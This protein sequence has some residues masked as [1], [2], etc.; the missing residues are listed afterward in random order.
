MLSGHALLPSPLGSSPDPVA[1]IRARPLPRSISWSPPS[2]RTRGR[3][4]WP[5]SFLLIALSLAGCFA[6]HDDDAPPDLVVAP[7]EQVEPR[8]T[9][10]RGRICLPFAPMPEHARPLEPGIIDGACLLGSVHRTGRSGSGWGNLDLEYRRRGNTVERWES[11][12]SHEAQLREALETDAL[13]RLVRERDA[14]TGAESS[15]EHFFDGDRYAGFHTTAADSER[16]VEHVYELGRL[17]RT[18]S[19]YDGALANELRYRYDGEGRL[20]HGEIQEG[21][22]LVT[23]SVEWTYDEAGNPIAVH[24]DSG[25]VIT[26]IAFEYDLAGNLAR[27]HYSS[28]LPADREPGFFSPY[29]EIVGPLDSYESELLTPNDVYRPWSH[30]DVPQPDGCTRL[31]VGPS[32]GWREPIYTLGHDVA[33]PEELRGMAHPATPQ[34]PIVAVMEDRVPLGAHIEVES[35]FEHGTLA[36]ETRRIWDE[37]GASIEQFERERSFDELGRV[38]GERVWLAAGDESPVERHARFE[39]DAGGR[40]SARTIEGETRFEE[41][42]ERDGDRTIAYSLS[43][44]VEGFDTDQRVT[45]LYDDANRPVRS[46]ATLVYPDGTTLG[47]IDLAYGDRT[48]VDAVI[49]GPARNETRHYEL[50]ATGRMEVL[51]IDDDNDGAVD[52]TSRAR[53][54]AQGFVVEQSAT[55]NGGEWEERYLY[56]C[57]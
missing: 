31:P 16:S 23:R 12:G 8:I 53:R 13:R 43:T 56:D 46:E 2:G 10:T 40:I 57:P 21:D 27:R 49:S 26:D 4:A 42:H 24:Y 19:T 17:V 7:P 38:I 37:H 48:V 29:V 11:E 32:F 22:S 20:A 36:R 5:C 41:H 25:S 14:T 34:I 39:Y 47:T 6:N 1:R 45:F 33:L 51:D 50:D 9:V 52:M 3:G 44:S 55:Y 15:T 35:T 54:N 18:T 30:A 28:R